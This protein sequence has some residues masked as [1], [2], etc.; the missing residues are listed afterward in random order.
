[1]SAHAPRAG[2]DPPDPGAYAK[3]IILATYCCYA[4]AR[5]NGLAVKN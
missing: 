1:M 2:D 4:L 5:Q 3:Y